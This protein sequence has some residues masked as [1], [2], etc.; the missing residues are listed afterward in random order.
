MGVSTFKIDKMDAYFEVSKVT[1]TTTNQNFYSQKEAVNVPSDFNLIMTD[2]TILRVYPTVGNRTSGSL[3]GL[4][5]V[6]NT[7]ISGGILY[8]DRDLIQ[9][10]KPNA[11]EGNLLMTIKSGKNII[12]EGVKFKMSSRTGLTINSYGFTF[13]PDYD[14][15]N[16]IIIRNNVFEKLR[17]MSFSITDGFNILVENNTFIDSAQPTSL[18]DGGV[19]GY[20]INIEPVRERDATT[21]ELIYY[22]K[23]YDVII[24]NNKEINSRV[25]AFNIFLGDNITI[26]DNEIETII[27]YTF[28]TNCK[29][30][31]NSLSSPQGSTRPAINAGGE[32]ETVF[33]N[34]IYGNIITGYEVGVS[35]N[36]KFVNVFN[37]KIFNCTIGIQLK[38]STD[39]KI[40][41]NEIKNSTSFS[42]GI[43]AHL[44][45]VNNVEIFNNEIGVVTNPLY[46]VRL[47]ILASSSDYTVNVHDNFF[48]NGVSTFEDTRGVIYSNNTS[49]SGMQLLRAE[50]INIKNNTINTTGS[51]GINL[52]A[53]NYNIN[54]DNNNI[55]Y[56]TTGNY[57]CIKIATTTDINQIIN[58]ETN[59]CN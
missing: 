18:S 40:Y 27:G 54:I 24:K 39:M 15:S 21:G 41:G 42:R 26:E 7:R 57:Q 9:Y 2:N 56:P 48:D 51:H 32:G 59:T 58:L 6:S 8:G 50:D 34:E 28:A 46:F 37:N 23:V 30:R 52:M 19:V 33:G 20:A 31:N 1:S 10:S 3:I 12:V 29:I 36:H 14:P 5:G 16:N 11:E 35:A 44:A 4:D 49:N 25:G 53:E 45:N 55:T 17:A 47:N 43:M 38:E 22:Q 13:N